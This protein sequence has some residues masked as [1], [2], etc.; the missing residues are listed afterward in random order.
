MYVTFSRDGESGDKI[1]ACFHANVDEQ[2][3][4]MHR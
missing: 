3:D 2:C 1:M 4:L